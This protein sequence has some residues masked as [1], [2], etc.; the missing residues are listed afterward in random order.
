MV[1]GLAYDLSSVANSDERFKHVA[2]MLGMRRGRGSRACHSLEEGE[3][4]VA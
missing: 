2:E 4:E 3:E 1:A